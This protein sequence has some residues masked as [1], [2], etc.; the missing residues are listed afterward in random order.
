LQIERIPTDIQVPNQKPLITQPLDLTILLNFSVL[1]DQPE[2][3]NTIQAQII[4]QDKDGIIRIIS[5]NSK[6]NFY[7]NPENY[8]KYLE[9]LAQLTL[10]L[11]DLD[12]QQINPLK[13]NFTETLIEFIK[14]GKIPEELQFLITLPE[15]HPINIEQQR[16]KELQEDALKLVNTV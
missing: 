1:V 2:L 14:T 5:I 13:D 10:I 3:N 11:N 7:I 15:Q 4:T 16:I 8:E 12:L 6:D 9:R